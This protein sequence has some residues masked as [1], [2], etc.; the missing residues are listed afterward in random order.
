MAT[1]PDTLVFSG[2]GPDGLAFVGCLRRLEAE[3]GLLERV[4][5]V[6]GCSAGAIFALFVAVGM[7]SAEIEA[8][9]ERGFEDRS[10]SDV[11]IEG[12]LT[13]VD[14]LGIDDGERVMASVRSAVARKLAE[15]APR[16]SRS[17]PRAASGDPTFL[18]L[19]KATGK[20]LVICVTDLEASERV[21]LSVD[22][23]PDLGVSLA[24]R[25]SISIPILFTP[26]RARL[27]PTDP[28]HTYVD[29]GLFDFC[30]ISH[31]VASGNA[32]S[33]L[34]FRIVSYVPC[35][36]TISGDARLTLYSYG[37]MIMRALLMR[38]AP[39]SCLSAPREDSP[40]T[41]VTTVDVPSMMMT[42]HGSA[43]A[44]DAASFSLELDRDGLAR[45][46]RHGFDCADAALAHPGKTS[47]PP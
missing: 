23:A 38:S 40:P 3:P 13:A 27:R 25:M 9:A 7:T 31:I 45:Y 21:L 24:V 18:E 46:V 22:T 41:L 44:F 17:D 28:I 37:S 26:V 4:R 36:Q 19:A 47:A 43:V 29:G 8:W 34:A 39:S 16:M 11:D 32:T 20:D 10:L 30:P 35:P 42:E 14:R 15:I 12:I 33:T 2:G 6:V 5:T 1:K